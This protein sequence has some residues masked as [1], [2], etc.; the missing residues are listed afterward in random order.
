MNKPLDIL[1]FGAHPDDVEL[2]AG[3]TLLKMAQLGHR[4]GIV[5]M[6]RGERGT[7]GSPD[8]R[9]RE[10][11]ASAKILRL[12]VRE[13][14]GLPDAHLMVS[15]A[16]RLKVI[17]VVRRWR[18]KIVLTHFWDDPHPDH[19]ITSQ[20]VSDGCFLSGLARIETGRPRFRP[21]KVLYFMLPQGNF[22]QP[23]LVVDISAHFA[24]KIRACRAYKSQFYD[25]RSNELETRLSAADF[26]ERVEV[27]HRQY[28]HLIGAKYGEGF[29]VKE[30]LRVDDP[31]AFFS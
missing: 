25:P 4:T 10:A 14:L 2:M 24:A 28:G 16:A 18:P 26:L 22:V 19:R 30:M 3:G 21:Q 9:A 29:F 11:R 7:R 31:V 13:N 5:D 23:T 15:D 1:A 8:L 6:T 17:E 27:D 20:L 12:T